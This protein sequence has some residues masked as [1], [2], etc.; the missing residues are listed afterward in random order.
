MRTLALFAVL[1]WCQVAT[2]YERV[3]VVAFGV[4]K[5]AS[6]YLNLASPHLDAANIA[7]VFSTQ[8]RVVHVDATVTINTAATYDAVLDGTRRLASRCNDSTLSVFFF[9]GHGFEHGGEAFM[10]PHDFDTNDVTTAV[11]FRFVAGRL[12]GLPGDVICILDCCQA[13]AASGCP[14]FAAC[15]ASE[16]AGEDALGG[17]FTQRLVRGLQGRADANNDGDVTLFEVIRYT[18]RLATPNQHPTAIATTLDVTLVKGRRSSPRHVGALDSTHVVP[19]V[20]SY[21]TTPK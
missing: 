13:G 11:P 2:P 14:T 4:S 8:R 1:L 17:W 10:L 16:Y 15:K 3:N 9:A 5:Y 18:S 6:S 7:T 21:R 20:S 19:L 12:Q